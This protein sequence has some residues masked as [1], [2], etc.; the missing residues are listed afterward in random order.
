MEGD[1]RQAD[2]LGGEGRKEGSEGKEGGENIDGDKRT[3]LGNT[4]ENVDQFYL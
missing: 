3:D 2:F 1:W 4:Q